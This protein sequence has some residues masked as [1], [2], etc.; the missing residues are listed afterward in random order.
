MNPWLF[1]SVVRAASAVLLA[2]A[3]FLTNVV[4]AVHADTVSPVLGLQAVGLLVWATFVAWLI[5]WYDLSQGHALLIEMSNRVGPLD[6]MN[7]YWV[8]RRTTIAAGL[9]TA[10]L[11]TY[12][13]YWSA[14]NDLGHL[15]GLLLVGP[16]VVCL[17]MMFDV[18]FS[19]RG[20]LKR[21]RV[22]WAAFATRCS[23]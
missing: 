6:R 4:L 21:E 16:A 22:L 15:A 17:F 18:L 19:L 7:L 1:T 10:A 23:Y 11:A 8:V 20:I 13:G 5:W 12:G 9:G 3:A 2:A 14:S